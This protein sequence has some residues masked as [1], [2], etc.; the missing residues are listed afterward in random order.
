[1]K[2][3]GLVLLVSIGGLSLMSCGQPN[4]STAA[5]LPGTYVANFSPGSE[6]LVPK[7]DGTCEQKYV[8]SAPSA[9]Q[10]NTGK[11]ELRIY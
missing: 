1:M 11:W 3:I 9:E 4:K 8:P 5:D 7:S 6:T 10:T 2:S